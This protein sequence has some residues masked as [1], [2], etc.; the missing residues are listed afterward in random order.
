MS[1]ARPRRVR[2]TPRARLQRF[3]LDT[4]VWLWWQADDRRLGRHARSTIA[5]APEVHVSAASI[6]EIAI[7]AAL[8][9]LDFPEDSPIAEELE[10]D[11]FRS[12]PITIEHAMAVRTLP[13]IHRDPF[14]R[15]LVA[16]AHI[17]GLVI[18]TAD[19]ILEHYGAPV[20]SATA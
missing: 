20:L 13:P 16:Q 9:K 14:D 4:Q 3:L 1:P 15:M 5:S 10:R 19:S 8:G 11:G 6:W 7:K 18:I 2:E 17:E 12:M